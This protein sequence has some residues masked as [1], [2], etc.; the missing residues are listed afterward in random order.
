MGQKGT[1]FYIFII[2]YGCLRA[3]ERGETAVKKLY[4]PIMLAIIGGFLTFVSMNELHGLVITNTLLGA[5]LGYAI[6]HGNS[7]D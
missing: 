1:M 5:I 2:G 7:L 3:Q 4:T 6:N